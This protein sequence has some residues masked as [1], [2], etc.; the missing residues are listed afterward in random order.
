MI[1]LNPAGLSPFH[2]EVQ[3]EISQALRAFGHLLY[4]DAGVRHYRKTLQQCRRL[5]EDWLEVNDDQ[6]VAFMPNATTACCLT[7]ARISWKAGDS[8]VTTT[9]ENSTILQEINELKDRGVEIIAIDP[10]SP[11]GLLSRLEK[12]VDTRSVRA[13]V[14]SHVSHLDG[15]IFPIAMIQ[16]L[17]QAHGVL[18]IV[19]GAQAVG[20]IPVSFQS[21]RPS[22]Y[23][24]PGHKWCAGP[25]GTGAL[26][27]RDKCEESNAGADNG[28]TVQP[29]T[30]PYW[31]RYEL[32]TQNIGLIAGLTKACHLTHQRTLNNQ[33]LEQ[34]RDEWKVCLENY[35]GLRIIEWEGPHAPGILSF[36][37]LDTQ[38]EQAMQTLS[39][40]HSLAWKT[41]T[42]PAYP[43]CLSIRVSWTTATPNTELRS[44][45][46]CLRIP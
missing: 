44:A 11:I 22:A 5:I 20:H 33:I 38:T 41:F 3:Q 24:F 19:D 1:Y 6:Q 2:P 45:L 32:G 34:V 8:L 40:T 4:S 39:V 18:L 23:F 10:N 7:L 46:A 30:Q 15:R 43:S 27:L 35:S 26:I 13:I 36:A 28:E 17:A 16:D 9:H 21:I 42:H 25:M 14:V 29:N 31:T 12:T 37:C